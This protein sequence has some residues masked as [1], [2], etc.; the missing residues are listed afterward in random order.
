[1]EGYFG[2]MREKV[3]EETHREDASVVTTVT[4]IIRNVNATVLIRTAA[5]IDV[6]NSSVPKVHYMNHGLLNLIRPDSR[7]KQPRNRR[8]TFLI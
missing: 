5:E 6:F 2:P 8:R 7:S 3:V 4:K 1:M